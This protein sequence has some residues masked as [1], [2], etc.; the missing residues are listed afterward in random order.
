MP[1]RAT[2]TGEEATRGRKYAA[3]QERK[4]TRRKTKE[5]SYADVIIKCTPECEVSMW[6]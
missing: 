2:A 5:D 6:C 4:K 1:R 3:T